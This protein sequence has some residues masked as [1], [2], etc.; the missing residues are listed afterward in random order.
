MI[1]PLVT[2]VLGGV[3][4]LIRYY[5]FG[6]IGILNQDYIKAARARGISEKTI[7][8]KHAFKNAALPIITILGLSLSGLISG[9]FIIE[10]V[11]SWPGMGQLGISAVFARDYPVLMGTILFSAI[12]IIL[13]NF[14][15][16]MAYAWV[17]PRIR[18]NA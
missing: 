5:R 6:I 12:L 17:D 15:A 13:G 14:L 2:I 11:C 3:A 7:L 1:L 10:F 9:A 16:D 8:F 18:R 4:G